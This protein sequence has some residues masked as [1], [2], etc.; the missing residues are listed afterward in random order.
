MIRGLIQVSPQYR[1]NSEQ[2][3][4]MKMITSR[5]HLLPQY[6]EIVDESTKEEKEKD[7]DKLLDTIRVP[8]NLSKLTQNL[9]K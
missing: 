9:P 7:E 6:E 4:K 1:P 8:K 2:I 5:L 3:L